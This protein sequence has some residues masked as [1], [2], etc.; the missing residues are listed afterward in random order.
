MAIPT[1][2]LFGWLLKD[3]VWGLK[4][5]G[6]LNGV[7]WGMALLLIAYWV[8]ERDDVRFYWAHV[9]YG[10]GYGG[11]IVN[12]VVKATLAPEP[13]EGAADWL[14]ML[15]TIK[16]VVNIGVP[17]LMGYIADVWSVSTL[18]AM[19]AAAGL[20]AGVFF[21]FWVPK[22]RIGE[23]AMEGGRRARRL[24]LPLKQPAQGSGD[25]SNRNDEETNIYGIGSDEEGGALLGG[26]RRQ[27]TGSEAARQPPSG[28][29]GRGRYM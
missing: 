15:H 25:S 8:G 14:A 13:E 17:P 16:D 12:E 2:L 19:C 3:N 21:F 24:G 1:Q 6:L 10:V 20:L 4:T 11:Y 22:K 18:A 7:L 23:A 27:R 5:V 28:S 9:V 26:D 29:A